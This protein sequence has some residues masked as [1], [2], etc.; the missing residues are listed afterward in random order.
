MNARIRMRSEDIL[1]YVDH[2]LQR[3]HQA[4]ERYT[5]HDGINIARYPLK[6]LEGRKILRKVSSEERTTLSLQMSVEMILGDKAMVYLP[7]G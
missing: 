4:H 5:V 6:L 1:H 3:A 2:F 7:K